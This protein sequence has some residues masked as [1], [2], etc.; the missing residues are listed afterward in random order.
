LEL[1]GFRRDR[2]FAEGL[3]VCDVRENGCVKGCL[4][5]LCIAVFCDSVFQSLIF[6]I[7]LVFLGFSA[8][9]VSFF[10]DFC[11]FLLARA[12]FFQQLLFRRFSGF[13]FSFSGFSLFLLLLL[14]NL[15][16]FL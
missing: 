7:F 8:D 4:R 16:T 15:G 14:R 2:D 10:F 12:F 6:E 11:Q 5:G 3:A 9:K 13:R 1:R